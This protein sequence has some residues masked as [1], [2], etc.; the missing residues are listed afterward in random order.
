[1]A[2]TNT[3][4]QVHPYDDLQAGDLVEHPKWGIGSILHRSG[5]AENTKL[6]VTFPDLENSGQEAQKKL[7]A[8]FA[9]LRKVEDSRARA[10]AEQ[11]A[12][13]EER[14]RIAALKAKEEAAAKSA[15][16]ASGE[17]EEEDDEEEEVLDEAE[18]ARVL[19]I[20]DEEEEMSSQVEESDADWEEKDNS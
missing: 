10:E 14:E 5:R 7:K 2:D 17:A 12:R 13:E 18:A 15:A 4:T 20:E 8:A 9:K 11:K 6:V 1:M 16:A 3:L 19:N